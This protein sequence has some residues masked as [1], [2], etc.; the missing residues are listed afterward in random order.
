MMFSFDT[1]FLAAVDLDQ[2]SVLN[3]KCNGAILYG[4]RNLLYGAKLWISQHVCCCIARRESHICSSCFLSLG[5]V[6]KTEGTIGK[7]QCFTNNASNLFSQQKQRSV[8]FCFCTNISIVFLWFGAKAESCCGTFDSTSTFAYSTSWLH[9][10]FPCIHMGYICYGY[11]IRFLTAFVNRKFDTISGAIYKNV[12]A[13][14]TKNSRRRSIGY[15][16]RCFR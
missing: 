12:S 2:P 6:D 5:F 10:P 3:D 4:V 8:Y 9:S 1:D 15:I 7:V 16:L 13:D 14:M 11:N